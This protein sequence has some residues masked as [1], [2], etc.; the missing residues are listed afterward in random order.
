MQL[1]CSFAIK[2]IIM[3]YLVF[4]FFSFISSCG[5]YQE[6]CE[7]VTLNDSSFDPLSNSDLHK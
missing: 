5:I 6:R 2:S 4:F 7:G 3:K 1:F